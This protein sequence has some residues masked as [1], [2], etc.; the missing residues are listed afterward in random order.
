MRT[1]KLTVVL[2]ALAAVV[3]TPACN[4]KQVPANA[5]P[6]VATVAVARAST[7]DLS[8]NLVMTGEFKAFQEVDVMAKVSGYVKKMYVDVGDRVKE[9]QLLAVIEIPEMADDM[10]RASAY[11][12][13]GSAEV[14]KARE[15]VRRAES[16][17]EIAHLSYARLASVMKD[18]PGLIAQQ[19]VDDA[20]SRD[21]AAEAQVDAARSSLAAAEQQVN[22]AQ[23]EQAKVKTL[24]NYTNVTAPFAGVVTKRVADNGSMIQAGTSSSSMPLVRISQNHVLRLILPVPESVVPSIHAGS[25]VD[26]K[27]PTLGRTIL[28]RVAR[29]SEHVRTDTRTM[30]TEVDVP[31]PNLA[32]MPGMYA[33]AGLNLE[34]RTSAL[35]VPLTAVDVNTEGESGGQKLEGTF[36]SVMVV[37]A[38]N[39]LEKRRVKLGLETADRAEILEGVQDGELVVIGNRSGLQEGQAVKAKETAPSTKG[40]N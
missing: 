8:R 15:E 32:L 34:R 14:R 6:D 36:G 2:A 21:L 29:F 33:E 12:A 40:R 30:D 13:R 39:H 26:V 7:G 20:R 18:K 31:N 35:Y 22:V 38:S 16:T 10:T 19:E 37:N 3:L 27:V 11:V 9:G 23:A 24:F 28:G 17:H 5:A 4:K 1:I 25:S